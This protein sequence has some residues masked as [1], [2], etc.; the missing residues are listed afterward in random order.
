MKTLPH[1]PQ[2]GSVLITV[3]ILAAI[4]AISLTSYLSLTTTAARLSNRTYLGNVCM[5]LAETGLEQAVWSFNQD[6]SGIT[7]AWDGWTIDGTNAT[8]KWK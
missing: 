1:H 4:V 3:L 2:R 6:T 5:N 7:T 8:R